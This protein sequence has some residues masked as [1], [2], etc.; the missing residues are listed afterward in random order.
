MFQPTG[1]K[2]L[3]NVSVI[4][5]KRGRKRFEIAC[6]PS[7]VLSYRAGH[8]KDLSEVLQVDEVFENVSKGKVAASGDLRECFG[9]TD[10]AKIIRQILERG[11]LQVS[12][13]ERQYGQPGH[14]TPDTGG[15]GVQGAAGGA[16]LGATDAFG[17]GTG[18]GGD[19]TAAAAQ[20]VGSGA[21][22]HAVASA[23]ARAAR[24]QALAGATG[25][26]RNRRRQKGQTRRS[27]QRSAGGRRGIGPWWQRHLRLTPDGAG[28]VGGVADGRR[29]AVD[30]ADRSGLVPH[31][32]ADRRRRDARQRHRGGD[33]FTGVA[34]GRPPERCLVNRRVVTVRWHARSERRSRST[35]RPTHTA[36]S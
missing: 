32:R 17:E 21:R 23:R 12:E 16:L 2:R 28:G 9:T 4:R 19:S 7:T 5:Y 8:L 26:D 24:R 31:A 22:A 10:R 27:R 6:Y 20:R 11:E 29:V 34:R 15:S 13:R 25:A 36:R 35:P 3:T 18:A 30:V 14:S 33:Q 1:Q